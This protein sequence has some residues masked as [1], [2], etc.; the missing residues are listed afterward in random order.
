MVGWFSG[1]WVL[2]TCLVAEERRV[3][4]AIAN[5]LRSLQVSGCLT[6]IPCG[7]VSESL[8]QVD[9]L[10]IVDDVDT[11]PSNA[12]QLQWQ[13][14]E[15]L[16]AAT[17]LCGVQPVLLAQYRALAAGDSGRSVSDM[18]GWFDEVRHW[19]ARALTAIGQPV[20]AHMR[21]RPLR[22]IGNRVVSVIETDASRR[23]FFRA[24]D[25]R[26]FAE[27]R[28][29]QWLSCRPDR[30]CPPTVMLDEDRGWWLCG[31]AEGSSLGLDAT[32]AQVQL[33]VRSF[34]QLQIE[35]IEHHDRLLDCGLADVAWSSVSDE[36]AI[37]LSSLREDSRPGT[38]RAD[39]RTVEEAMD[40]TADICHRAALLDVP[41]TWVD[42]D[43]GYDN[44]FV[45]SRGL[46][47]IDLERS[48]IAFPHIALESFLANLTRVKP[49][50]G[51][52]HEPLRDVYREACGSY[53]PP[54]AIEEAEAVAP[55]AA[56]LLR[57]AARSRMT[58]RKI[59]TGELAADLL[60]LRQ[61]AASLLL[62]R[63]LRCR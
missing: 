17:A 59:E 25:G 27:A 57:V 39:A 43:L 47:L 62:G 53:A 42:T 15:P 56:R 23:Y 49:A 8:E 60:H 30:P 46:Q 45:S 2:P 26:P 37:M 63:L 50:A 55:T 18:P 33:V 22:A 3:A 9:W 6:T 40:M 52:W 1:K 11:A 16:N 12:S 5:A 24:S 7:H 14:L 29:S 13:T 48:M 10:A 19:T 58:K 41:V 51:D 35:L 20:A 54:R 32:L 31:E 28:L 34:A 38:P 61:R 44:V 21:F 36:I 4:E